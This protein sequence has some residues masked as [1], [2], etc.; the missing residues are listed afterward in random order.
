MIL[1]GKSAL[2]TGSSRGIGKAI[3]LALADAG[4]DVLVNYRARDAEANSVVTEI[5][6]KGR[7]AIC[8]QADVGV[9][10][11]VDRM[12]QAAL[13]AF[14]KIDVLVN[15]AGIVRDKFLAF[16]SEAD[17]DEVLDTNLKGAFFC[18]KAVSKQMVRQKSGKIINIS[19]AAGLLGDMLR[20][21]YSAAKA[22]MIGMTKAA[23]RELAARGVTVNALA[24]GLIE[25]EITSDMKDNRRQQLLSMIPAA[26]FGAPEEVA[27]VVVF[28][29]SPAADYLTGQV[30]SVDGGLRM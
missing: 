22:G 13:E 24:P 10:T 4:A 30:L 15:N 29:A 6:S 21:N 16:M 23:A 27:S 8:V 17:W 19:S 9:A 25:T 3:A 1:D 20:V 7:R 28:L 14:G 2:V 12:V 5:E 18:T 11:D 26:R